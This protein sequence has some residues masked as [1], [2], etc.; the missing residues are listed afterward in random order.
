MEDQELLI[1]KPLIGKEYFDEL[2]T[3]L[4]DN[5]L[6]AYDTEALKYIRKCVANY[7]VSSAV[8]QLAVQIDNN[9]VTVFSSNGNNDSNI[10][11]REGASEARIEDFKNESKKTASKYS[12]LLMSYLIAEASNIPTWQAS[13]TYTTLVDGLHATKNFSNDTSSTSFFM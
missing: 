4:A 6:S 9:G 7:T 11:M 3:K 13:S 8:S 5:T 12:E 10:N 1:I 2:K